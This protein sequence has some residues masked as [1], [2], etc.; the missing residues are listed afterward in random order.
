VGN[1]GGAVGIWELN[2][3]ASKAARTFG[4]DRKVRRAIRTVDPSLSGNGFVQTFPKHSL[5]SLK[6]A[7]Q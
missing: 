6:L 5:T 2:H 3:P 4:D 7:V 1:P